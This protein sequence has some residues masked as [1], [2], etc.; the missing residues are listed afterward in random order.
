MLPNEKLEDYILKGSYKLPRLPS[1]EDELSIAF[2]ILDEAQ[3]Q[4]I[5]KWKCSWPVWV[6]CKIYGNGRSRSSR[7]KE[8]PFQD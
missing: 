2:V 5:L 4:H 7:F 8:E 1:C 3:I 6:K